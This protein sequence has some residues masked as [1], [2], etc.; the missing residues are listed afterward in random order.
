LELEGRLLKQ[1]GWEFYNGYN[2]TFQP[3]YMSAAELLQA[4]RSLWR[5]AFSFRYTAK[6][7]LRSTFRLR[8]G[9]ILLSLLMNSFYGLK[10]LRNN[11]PLDIQ[12]RTLPQETRIAQV[13]PARGY[14]LRD[15]IIGGSP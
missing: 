4:H 5:T 14:P 13:T 10:S 15:E 11:P 6:R 12:R 2:V 1:R 7:I 8:L 3:Q 9:A